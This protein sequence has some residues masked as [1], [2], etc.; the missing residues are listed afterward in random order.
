[1][2][3]KASRI[4]GYGFMVNVAIPTISSAVYIYNSF[5]LIMPMHRPPHSIEAATPPS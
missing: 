5:L 1:M 4:I 2:N 3:E